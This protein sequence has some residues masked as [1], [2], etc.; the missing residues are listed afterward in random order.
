LRWG[1]P[2]NRRSYDD[3]FEEVRC[4]G[5]RAISAGPSDR[6]ISEIVRTDVTC[7]IPAVWTS[8]TIAIRFDFNGLDEERHRIGISLDVELSSEALSGAMQARRLA[9]SL[10]PV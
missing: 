8:I 2:P 3:V 1:K 5:A 4:R 7:G 6:L 10:I 9:R